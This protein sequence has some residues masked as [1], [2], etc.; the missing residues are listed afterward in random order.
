MDN[1][2]SSP[3]IIF[4]NVPDDFCPQ[5]N[6]TQI[7]QEFIDEVLSNGTVNI[8]GLQAVTP[9][10][11][12]SLDARVSLLENKVNS[13]PSFISYTG[14]ATGF[15]ANT[16]STVNVTFPDPLPSTNYTISL[17]MVMP[18]TGIGTSDPIVGILT[19]SKATT[20][21]TISL[22]NNGAS[23]NNI[24]SIEWGVFHT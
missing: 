24:T 19:S 14:V 11:I 3:Q 10:Q 15:T 6:W 18:A 8:S 2:Y 16:D 12:Q 5:G 21:F 9:A 13:L 7:L 23:P 4:P 20:G 17:T 22:Q 1:Q